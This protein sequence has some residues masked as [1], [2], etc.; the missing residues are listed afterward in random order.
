[1]AFEEL[2]GLSNRLLTNA[3]GLA[4]PHRAAAPRRAGRRGRPGGTSTA[5]PGGRRDRRAGARPR[6][7]RRRAVGGV[8]VRA[9]LSC[10]GAG[11]RREPSSR[12]RVDLRRS[13]ATRGAGIGVGGGGAADR[14]RGTGD[15]GCSDSRRRHRRRRAGR[16]VRDQ[17]S[18]S[19]VVGVDPWSRRSNLQERSPQRPPSALLQVTVQELD[20]PDG[21]DL[22]WLPSFF[23]PEPVLDDAVARI[24]SMMRPGGT[25]VV[26]IQYGEREESLAS[27]VDDLFTVRS[28]RLRGRL[29]G[30][31]RPSPRCW[32]RRH[33][34]ARA[35]M[36][37]AD[38]SRRR[39]ARLYRALTR[40]VQWSPRSSAT[41]P[42]R[43]PAFA[44]VAGS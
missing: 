3:Q 16:G 41:H 39:P 10:A 23:I 26:G 19:T 21:F 4:R 35:Q 43:A 7:R 37:R 31:A 12:R 24:Y 29:G 6:D 5:R 14:R 18:Q 40:S 32:F 15:G 34:G 33:A 2:M 1:M 27:A 11:S 42:D 44:G 38:Q 8:V 9:F 28:G 20:D 25:L 13:S 22:A 17:V 36:G 30:R